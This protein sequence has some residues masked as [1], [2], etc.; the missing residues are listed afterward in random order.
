MCHLILPVNRMQQARIKQ[1]RARPIFS[2]YYLTGSTGGGISAIY[3]GATPTNVTVGGLP[4]GSNVSGLS[5]SQVLEKM[6]VTYLSPSF[7]SFSITSQS[8]QIEVQQLT[9]N[10]T[11]TWSTSNSGNI[12]P[13]SLLIRD[14]TSNAIIANNLV[15]DGSEVI[16][17][18]VNLTTPTSNSWR[19]E[20]INT[21]GVG[22][23]SSN[24]TI[25]SNYPCFMGKITSATRPTLTNANITGS[26]KFN[27]TPTS[28]FTASIGSTADQ[29]VFFAQP[30]AYQTKT[31]WYQSAL[32][33]GSI[34][35]A[36]SAGSNLFPDY[37]LM[38]LSSGIWSNIQYKVYLSNYPIAISQIEIRNN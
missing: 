29:Y 14:V 11:F 26:S 18:N 23:Q 1:L 33:T 15:N 5:L 24:F 25:N 2:N 21:N 30:V 38:N 8:T 13:N 10:K 4:A 31:V 19:I 36:V 28:N 9:G 17:L 37:F 35:G 27:A 34:G 16:N 32:N 6:I 22:F 12:Q 3:T 20:G 7:G